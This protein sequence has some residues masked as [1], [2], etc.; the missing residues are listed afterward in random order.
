MLGNFHTHT[1][2]DDGKSTPEEIVL[3]AIDRGFDS[4]G[5]SGHGY[6][7]CEQRYCM[8][9]TKGF[10]REI[11]RLKDVY[12]K[13]LQIYL[14]SEED[15]SNPVYRGDYDYIIS[16][17][18]YFLIDGV[19]RPIDSN[20]DYFSRCMEEFH[21]DGLALAESY[22]RNFCSF[23]RMRK[24]D[25]IGHFDLITK[26]EEATPS[27]Y[28][29]NPK[30]IALANKWATYAAES[31]SLFEMNTG[32]ITRGFR[33]TPYPHVELLHTLKKLDAGIILSSDSHH[34]DTLTYGF[35][36]CK[37]ILRDVGFTHVYILW[38]GEFIKDPI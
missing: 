20:F 11:Q 4:L 7:Y 29:N 34:K 32:A 31:G 26:F 36:E 19:C 33:K 8:M 13:K 27:Q 12:G 22:Y 25:I 15:A 1:T 9:D 35:E 3:E 16:S 5:F 2:F 37:Q 23:I 10:I 28:F 18:H 30:Y 14:G 24:P 17:S 6:T 38:D 21:G